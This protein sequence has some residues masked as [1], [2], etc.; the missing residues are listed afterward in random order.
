MYDLI[1]DFIYNNLLGTATSG[2]IPYYDELALL[3]THVSL[4]LVYAVLIML[5][6]HVFNSFRS[7]TRFW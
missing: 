6:V 1:Y 4:W 2:T 3:M 7:M 5:L